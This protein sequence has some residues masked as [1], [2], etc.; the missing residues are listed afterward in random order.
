[1]RTTLPYLLLLLFLAA[2]NTGVPGA[3]LVQTP[4]TAHSSSSVAYVPLHL[5]GPQNASVL[6]QVEIADTPA[7]Q[8]QGLMGRTQLP[9][10]TGMLFVFSQE[11][12]L[13][14]WMKDTLIPL[15]IVFFDAQ[16]QWVSHQT[17]I[18][19]APGSECTIYPSQKPSRYALELPA[20]SLQKLPMAIGWSMEI[21]AL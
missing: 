12:P 1:M 9:Q 7:K 6:L 10:D 5:Y 19:C 15:D 11:E 14:F 2:C 21:P 18:P 3:P 17:M 8:E 4:Q 16:G 13:S 20:G